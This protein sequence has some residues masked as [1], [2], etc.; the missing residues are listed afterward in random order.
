MGMSAS[1]DLFFG[2]ITGDPEESPFY[3]YNE[4]SENDDDT[5]IMADGTILSDEEA[6]DIYDIGDYLAYRAGNPDME[7]AERRKLEEASPVAVDFGG[8]CDYP[9]YCLVLKD[10]R[11]KRH[12]Y[13]GVEE[14]DLPERPTQDEIDAAVKFCAENGLPDFSAATWLL[15]A[16][17]G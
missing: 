16:N 10:E 17:F 9:Q 3:K 11:Y 15:S 14:I 4:D 1:A 7:Y 6:Q 12:T 8:T 13:W 2:I 5:Y